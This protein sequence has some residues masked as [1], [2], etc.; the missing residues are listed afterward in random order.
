MG[1]YDFLLEL[2]KN[3]FENIMTLMSFNL[4]RNPNSICFR[5]HC[6]PSGK[7]R[8]R[9]KIIES[10]APQIKEFYLAGGTDLALLLGHGKSKELT[11][12]N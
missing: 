12:G 1:S 4:K 11:R 10:L 9:L 3:E 6:K 5:L 7:G 8:K 2:A